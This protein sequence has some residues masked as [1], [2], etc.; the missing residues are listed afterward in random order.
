VTKRH[1]YP[2]G[3]LLRHFSTSAESW[4]STDD[5]DRRRFLIFV[6]DARMSLTMADGTIQ[7]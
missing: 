5:I 7:L 2:H 3:A 4:P 6:G 1:A